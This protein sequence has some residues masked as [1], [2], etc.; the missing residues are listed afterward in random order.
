[1][2]TR[3]QSKYIFIISLQLEY[4]VFELRRKI[5]KNQKDKVFFEKILALKKDKIENISSQKQIKNIFNEDSLKRALYEKVYGSKG[6]PNFDVILYKNQQQRD[7]Y[8]AKDLEFYYEIGSEMKVEVEKN[9]FKVGI[10]EKIFHDKG[11]C[12]V[13]LRKESKV[14]VLSIKCLTRIL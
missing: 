13:K 9:Q 7:E 5:Y 8:S 11:V 14:T 2:K 10:L 1:M 6:Y 4:I 12:H 3:N